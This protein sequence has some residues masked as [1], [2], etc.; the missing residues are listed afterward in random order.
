M[1]AGAHAAAMTTPPN[2]RY[3]LSRLQREWN[4]MAG[5]RSAVC[6]ASQWQLSPR[7]LDSLNDLLTLTGLASDLGRG[8]G[9]VDTDPAGEAAYD[10]VLGRLVVLARHDDLAARVVLQRMLP[11][12]S[13]C[14]SRHSLNFDGRID[15]FDELLAEAWSVIRSFPIEQRDRYVIKNLLRDCEYRTFIR[16]ARRKMV[17]ELV[18]PAHLDVAVETEPE[19]E[20]LTAIVE[21]LVK[22]RRTGMSAADIAVVT[23]LLN[24]SSIKE[25]AVVLRVTDRT[26]RNRRDVVVGQ[27]RTLADVA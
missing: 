16:S 10:A 5:K 4:Q 20:P 9:I 2:N 26:V 21:L 8:L 22:A 19:L 23:T 25:A 17:Y 6:H 18:D 12:L 1:R 7:M 13:A 14:A 24:T 27:L 15:A 3:I 11:G